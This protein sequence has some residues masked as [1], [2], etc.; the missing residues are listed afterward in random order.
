MKR[1]LLSHGKGLYLRL[2]L[3]GSEPP[4]GGGGGRVVVAKARREY[5]QDGLY[6]IQPL[7]RP[8]LW[9]NM[10]SMSRRPNLILFPIPRLP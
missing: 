6:P 4:G 5:N 9:L 10:G 8:F 7:K 1:V 2:G 3:K